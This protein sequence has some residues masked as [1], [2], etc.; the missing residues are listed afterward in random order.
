MQKRADRISTQ[1]SD[2]AKE[3]E[4]VA[5][6]KAEYEGKLREIEKQKEEILTAAKNLATE[7]SR[8]I[9]ADAKAEADAAR[10]RVI[11]EIELE[12]ER[13]KEQLR[14]VIIEVAT[15]MTEKLVMMSMDDEVY[16]RVF[17]E[18]VAELEE[19]NWRK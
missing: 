17:N 11:H 8:R 18:T 1:L 13:V 15:A 5:K 19:A 16:E 10:E 6:M 9:L 12:Q 7:S 2:A 14:Q 4:H 3:A